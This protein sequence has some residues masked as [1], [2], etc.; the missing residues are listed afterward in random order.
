MRD[1]KRINEILALISSLW[2]T[3]PDLRLC[4]LIGNCF[5]AKDLYYI[6][7]EDLKQKLIEKYDEVH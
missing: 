6:E 1:S 2:R 3:Y 5:E 4:Q 7:D